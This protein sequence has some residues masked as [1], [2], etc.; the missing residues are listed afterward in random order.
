VWLTFPNV[1]ATVALLILFVPAVC[2]Y[3]YFLSHFFSSSGSALV[4]VLLF[5]LFVGNI[6]LEI[7]H[8]MMIF[9]QT[10]K[11]GHIMLWT[12]RALV[13]STCIGNGLLN[14]AM[15]K[16]VSSYFNLSPF[17]GYI[18]GS[19]YCT[20]LRGNFPCLV[21]AGDDC[22]MLVFD[23]IVYTVL[24]T[25]GDWIIEHPGFAKWFQF[26]K[27]PIC[28]WELRRQEDAKVLAEKERVAGLDPA[29]QVLM[30]SNVSKVFR[31]GKGD[32]HAVRGVSFAVEAGNVFGLLGTNGAGK[33]TT[34]KIIC[35]QLVPSSGR[36]FVKGMDVSEDLQGVRKHIGYCPQFDALLELMTVHEHLELFARIKGLTGK[37]LEDEVASKLETLHLSEYTDS[38]AGQLSGGNK[39]KLSTAMALIGEP[40]VVFLD[41][42]SAGM[43]PLARR[44]MWDVIQTV[45]MRRSSSAVVL[46][47]HSMEEAD[48]LCTRIG[49]QCSGQLRCLGSPQQLKEWYG[50]GLELN[51]R[52]DA[53]SHNDSQGLC[54]EWLMEPQMVCH[55]SKARQLVD[56]FFATRQLTMRAPPLAGKADTVVAAA[57]AE[58]CLQEARGEEVAAFLSDACGGQEH[59][60]CVERSAGSLRY[61]L[62]GKCPGGGPR[63]YSELFEA[64][65]QNRGQLHLADF[66]LSQGSLEQTFNR[67]AAEDIALRDGSDGEEEG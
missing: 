11:A 49:I 4:G 3:A 33:T 57:L 34:F 26:S 47:T 46:T 64:L 17:S 15:N 31:T 62:M 14:L 18:F 16:D 10:R 7:S 20:P 13:P 61:K 27:D 35:G 52:M 65:E 6:G 9:P 32:V 51:M 38:R 37:V 63:P 24:C 23:A 28:P 66:Q 56:E 53:P 29:S 59:A 8:A 58:W 60:S 39:R 21:N 40:E 55:M 67:L 22:A 48:A 54:Q 1:E 44:R 36:V 50:T 5:G 12:A 19:E 42:P 45:A 30:V 25:V 43:D 2:A 41:E